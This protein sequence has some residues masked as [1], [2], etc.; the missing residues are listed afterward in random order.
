[1]VFKGLIELA[2]SSF[3][4]KPAALAAVNKDVGKLRLNCQRF[5]KRQ[6]LH[7]LSCIQSLMAYE[8][9]NHTTIGWA[10]Q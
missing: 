10:S 1:V 6:G 2:A 9:R 4:M 7:K 5:L 8:R 3:E